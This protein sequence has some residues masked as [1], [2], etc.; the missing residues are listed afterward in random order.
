MGFSAR[1][2]THRI[3]IENFSS[4]IHPDTALRVNLVDRPWTFSHV[5]RCNGNTTCLSAGEHPEGL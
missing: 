2:L 3:D 1:F 4:R 5:A